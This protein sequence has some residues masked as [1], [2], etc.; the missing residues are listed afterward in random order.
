MN[1]KMFLSYF[2]T[3]V[4]ICCSSGQVVER[5][6]DDNNNN[7]PSSFKRNKFFKKMEFSGYDKNVCL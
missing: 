5:N 3:E 4:E 2:K 7:N 6:D 1:I